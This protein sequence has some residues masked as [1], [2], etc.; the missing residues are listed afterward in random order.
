[1]KLEEIDFDFQRANKLCLTFPIGEQ[2][3][4]GAAKEAFC[5]IADRNFDIL[6][7]LQRSSSD[8]VFAITP[9]AIKRRISTLL[10]NFEELLSSEEGDGSLY[11]KTTTENETT[12]I[13]FTN[14]RDPG[15]Q[16]AQLLG[17]LVDI[18]QFTKVR[19]AIGGTLS[20]R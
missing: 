16:N 9:E 8:W 5:K 14:K 17:A 12:W 18:L 1:M 10:D 20:V 11:L 4:I 2:P 6:P 3:D 15:C 19:K 7:V 13:F